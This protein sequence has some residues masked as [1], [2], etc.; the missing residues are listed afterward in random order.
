MVMNSKEPIQETLWKMTTDKKR[1]N[2]LQTDPD[3]YLVMLG[4]VHSQ[5][6]RS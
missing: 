1:W 2:Y 4:G 6:K 3:N 5:R